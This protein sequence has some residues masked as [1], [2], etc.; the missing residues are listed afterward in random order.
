VSRPHIAE[1]GDPTAAEAGHRIP[2]AGAWH[3]DSA[4]THIL[5]EEAKD[6]SLVR[7]ERPIQAADQGDRRTARESGHKDQLAET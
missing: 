4:D 7:G 3:T 2:A 5:R 6:H 1:A